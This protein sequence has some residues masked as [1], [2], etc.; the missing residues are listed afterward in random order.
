MAA[1]DPPLTDIGAIQAKKRGEKRR[2]DENCAQPDIVLC[3]TLLRAVETALLI[4][5][6]QNDVIV[7]PHLEEVASSPS[8]ED[9][10]APPEGY[11]RQWAYSKQWL[12]LGNRFP[13]ERRSLDPTLA[14]D[15]STGQYPSRFRPSYDKFMTWLSRNL[16]TVARRAGVPPRTYWEDPERPLEI[17]VVT[18]GNYMR[19]FVENSA[20]IPRNMAEYRET[21]RYFPLATGEHPRI[22]VEETFAGEPPP[23]LQV[24][25]TASTASTSACGRDPRS[26]CSI[27]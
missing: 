22:S 11:L 26:P 24:F 14:V 6:P 17:A 4:F 2:E 5:A 25:R 20:G 7:S 19:R 18:H 12:W 9:L 13:Q 27:I 8:V 23:S 10:T 1:V 16:G 3:S 21:G 15:H